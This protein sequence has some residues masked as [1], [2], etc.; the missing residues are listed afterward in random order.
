MENQ[1]LCFK[2]EVIDELKRQEYRLDAYNKL[3]KAS[4]Q[5]GLEIKRPARM[6]NGRYMT[7]SRWKGNYREVK[8]GKLDFDATLENLK[9]AQHILDTA[10][11]Q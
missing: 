1:E 8:E 5:L 7:V 4:E 10:F 2:I 3:A 6:G 9:K 11:L